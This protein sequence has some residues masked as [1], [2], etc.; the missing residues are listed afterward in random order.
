MI[1]A[2]AKEPFKTALAMV[3]AYG[4]ALAMDW[5]NPYWA[6]FAVAFV[7]LSTV[8]QSFNKAA[9]R[10][11]GTLVAV[12]VAL[13]LIG[14]FPQERWLFMV[15]LSSYI[16]LCTY[17]MTGQ[18]RQYFWNVCGLVCVI[19]CMSAGPDPVNAFDIVVLRAEETGLGILA[20]SLVTAL[21]WPVSNRKDFF[22]VTG[23][24]ASGQRQ[25]CQAGLNRGQESATKQA[26]V[27]KGPLLQAQTRFQQ[28]LL[29]AESDTREVWEMR[30]YWRLY[31]EQTT[32]LTETIGRSTQSLAELEASK[33]P[34]LLSNLNIFLDEID[35]RFAEIEK[36]LAGEEPEHHPNDIEL[37]QDT[38]GLQTLSHFEQAEVVVF[39]NRLQQLDQLTRA[40]FETVQ[41]IGG[42]GEQAAATAP[43]APLSTL[44][45]PDPDRMLAVIRVMLIM[46]IAYL[47]LIYVDS[48]PGGSSL[49]TIA[50]A[51]G[52]IVASMPMVSLRTIFIPL[53]ISVVFAC[54]VY[55][56]ILPHLSGFL[57]L[58]SLLFIVTF[59]ICYL[60]STPKQQ[61]GRTLALAMFVS[62]ASI[63]NQQTYSFMV[64]A[65]NMLMFPVLFMILAVT[66]YFPV[67]LR[68]EKSFLRLLDR[69]FHSCD[70]LLSG[71]H[72]D[73]QRAE[74]G[75]ERMRKA[76]HLREL[77][78]I[79]VKLG[80]W[81]KFL[82]I[83]V[84]PGTDAQDVQALLARLQDLAG[85]IKELVEVRSSLQN[86]FL[87]DELGDEAV[88]WRHKLQEAFESLGTAPLDVG[89]ET[90]RTRLDELMK[91]LEIRIRETLDR[92]TEEQFGREDG[93]HF[94][95]LLGAYR[96]VSES[97][98]GYTAT[99]GVIDWAP[100]HEERF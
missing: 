80:G 22:A 30:R 3:I 7:S 66:A 54:L 81:A 46:W 12:V 53:I 1:P 86:Q 17:L 100:W 56:F 51:F 64:V 40:Q 31:K 9:M 65:T 83:K 38:A 76:F 26:A 10:M 61:L 19:I 48:I 21:L 79:P 72:R 70:R 93:E 71:M 5:D 23:E 68:Q 11:F 36:M 75:V 96:G 74:T 4:I 95:R 14:L 43:R 29:A 90:Y 24:L 52:M 60:L 82:D 6:G 32:S 87:I 49:V 15:A 20:Y 91:R 85:R 94:Y 89:S 59:A 69:Y 58:G 73:V 13:L 34:P 2:K 97:V 35:K 67:N 18:K 88:D 84:L 33:T 57:S 41:T 47:G 27:L 62:I 99:A 45:W 55:L 28:L 50:G 77:S 8:G 16:G 44:Q 98:V 42:F 39:R 63:D 37:V 92:S 25:F 78:S